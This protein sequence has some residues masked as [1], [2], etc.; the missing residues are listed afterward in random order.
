MLAARSQ[1]EPEHAYEWMPAASGS[2]PL[3]VTIAVAAGSLPLAAW[4]ATV[5]L[6][7]EPVL[8]ANAAATLLSL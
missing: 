5:M 4:T 2:E 3:R 8:A 6:P 7:G 1:L